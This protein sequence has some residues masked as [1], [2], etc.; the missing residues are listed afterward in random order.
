MLEKIGQPCY[1]RVSFPNNTFLRFVREKVETLNEVIVA[2]I[3][4]GIGASSQAALNVLRD[5]DTYYIFDYHD[6]VDELKKDFMK[7]GTVEAK[8][9]S[10]GNTRNTNDSYVWT[11]YDLY[12]RRSAKFDLVLLDGAHDFVIDLACCVLIDNLLCHGGLIIVDDYLLTVDVIKSKKQDANMYSG[13][14]SIEQGSC[15]QMKMVCD[16]Y[17]E[18]N[19]NYIK[20]KVEDGC[21]AYEKV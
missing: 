2:E 10:C 12:S 4:V 7:L 6:K 14:Y 15:P 1:E 5:C 19:S 21:V 13:I 9:I 8:I 3:G 18:Y 20:K 17:F 11:L 16:T